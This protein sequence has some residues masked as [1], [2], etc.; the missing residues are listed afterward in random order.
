MIRV[1]KRMEVRH[2][3]VVVVAAMS[4]VSLVV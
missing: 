1:R 3:K 4:L 2:L